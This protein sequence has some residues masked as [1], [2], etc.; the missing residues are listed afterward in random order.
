MKHED[1]FTFLGLLSS[2]LLF[3]LCMWWFL[4]WFGY[5]F[6]THRWFV[7][8][9]AYYVACVYSRLA[10]VFIHY[11]VAPDQAHSISRKLVGVAVSPVITPAM[12]YA[13]TCLALS[14]GMLW[15]QWYL[16]LIVFVVVFVIWYC[17]HSRYGK[18]PHGPGYLCIA[19]LVAPRKN[20][21]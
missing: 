21:Q 7:L 20:A 3:V 19:N 16:P 13:E 15:P 18:G 1:V 9:I 2:V 12:L 10:S 6:K 8:G 5:G 4:R 17:I 11:Q 14:F